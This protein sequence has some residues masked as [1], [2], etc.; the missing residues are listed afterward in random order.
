MTDQAKSMDARVP[1]RE[2]CVLRY[3]LEKRADQHPDKAFMRLPDGDAISYGAFRASV[4]RAAAGLAALGVKQGDYVNVWLPNGVDM[5][6][7]WFAINWLGAVYVPINTA[8]RGN[9]L[10]HV[11]ANGGA[12]LMIVASDLRGSAR[13]YRSRAAADAC[14]CRRQGARHPGNGICSARKTRR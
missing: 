13:E 8:Y 6:R 7:I 4:E 3:V 11:I 5:V 1:S 10:A 12:E 14:R 2:D 9:V